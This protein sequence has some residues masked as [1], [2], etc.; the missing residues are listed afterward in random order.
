MSKVH[1]APE[2]VGLRCRRVPLQSRSAVGFGHYGHAGRGPNHAAAF[3]S[4]LGAMCS[5]GSDGEACDEFGRRPKSRDAEGDI[6]FS[7]RPV[8]SGT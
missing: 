7:Q 3:A 6:R 1:R 8:H 2:S 4:T 5:A